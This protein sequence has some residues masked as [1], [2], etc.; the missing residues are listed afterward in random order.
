VAVTV[1]KVTTKVQHGEKATNISKQK[2][3][4]PTVAKAG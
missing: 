3:S 1:N 4:L 2:R